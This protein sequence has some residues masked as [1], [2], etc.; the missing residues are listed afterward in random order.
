DAPGQ[1]DVPVRSIPTLAASLRE[2][3]HHAALFKDLATLRTDPPVIAA[4]EE[5]RW[6]GP[7][8]EFAQL[9][10]RIDAAQFASRAAALAKARKN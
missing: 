1:W 2:S 10:R 6:T 4:V 9:C 5:L 7:T 8:A 3:R